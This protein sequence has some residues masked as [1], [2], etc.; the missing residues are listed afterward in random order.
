[1]QA[2]E[3]ILGA[4]IGCTLAVCGPALALPPGPGLDERKDIYSRC[5][6]AGG[7]VKTCCTAAGGTI[8]L[9]TL[10][11]ESFCKIALKAPVGGLLDRLL[12]PGVQTLSK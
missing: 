6:D 5:T 3:F 9:D 12:S 11:G 4:L 10:T 8:K 1:M 2:R 7:T